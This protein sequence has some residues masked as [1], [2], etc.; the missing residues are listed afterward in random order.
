MWLLKQVS[1]GSLIGIRGRF[2]RLVR[3]A[4]DKSDALVE[5]TSPDVPEKDATNTS[6]KDKKLSVKETTLRFKQRLLGLITPQKKAYQ[7]DQP[8]SHSR[9]MGSVTSYK[10]LVRWT[11]GL[12]KSQTTMPDNQ[13]A[14]VNDYRHISTDQGKTKT[15]C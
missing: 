12:G 9:D 14:T 11:A 13:D 4:R 8:A 6:D 10:D 2:M 1:P 5:Q 3:Q 15:G 7:E